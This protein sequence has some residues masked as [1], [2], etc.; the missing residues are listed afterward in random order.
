MAR[1]G[2]YLS[3][4]GQVAMVHGCRRCLL[5]VATTFSADDGQPP[6]PSRTPTSRDDRGAT[7]LGACRAAAESA[8]HPG[9]EHRGTLIVRDLDVPRTHGRRAIPGCSQ[10]RTRQPSSRSAALP[11][12]PRRTPMT[13]R[14]HVS[15]GGTA[16]SKHAPGGGDPRVGLGGLEVPEIPHWRNVD[17][18]RYGMAAKVGA[19]RRDGPSRKRATLL[20]TVV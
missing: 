19:L 7:W 16:D 13:R 20:A 18:A 11:F 1:T 14:R 8:G 4:D 17:L 5:W 12:C 10:P 6:S 9:Q 2:R 15:P 3:A